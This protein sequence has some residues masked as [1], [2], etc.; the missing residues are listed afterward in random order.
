MFGW[1][2]KASTPWSTDR[3]STR[4]AQASII[5]KP[6]P[7]IAYIEPRFSRSASFIGAALPICGIDVLIV[8][9][10]P[11][12]LADPHECNLYVIAFQTR[13]GRAIVLVAQDD[14]LVP[15]YFGPLVIVRALSMLP[16]DLIPWRRML[17]R[18]PRPKPWQLPIPRDATE[19]PACEPAERAA[20]GGGAR[21][22]GRTRVDSR[23]D[24][25]ARYGSAESRSTAD[26]HAGLDDIVKTH[27]LERTPERASAL[28]R[29]ART[30]RR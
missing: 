7:G 20:G 1:K 12:V 24:A 14:L 10:Q 23:L 4:A 11:D 3:N 22:V 27:I 13:F 16:F 6:A 5:P 18:M 15:T 17:Y 30:T 21:Q 28:A 25:S 2:R 26:D 19:L 29:M 8:V 9:V